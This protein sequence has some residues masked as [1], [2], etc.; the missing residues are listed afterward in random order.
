MAGVD[1]PFDQLPLP[2]LIEIVQTLDGF[3]GLRLR[4]RGIQW[5][6]DH[7]LAL[8]AGSVKKLAFCVGVV[9]IGLIGLTA[10]Q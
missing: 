8:P 10:V 5:S 7:A 9:A 3:K 2:R 6:Y 4:Q 1:V